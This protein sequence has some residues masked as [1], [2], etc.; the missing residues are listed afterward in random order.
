MLLTDD[1]PKVELTPKSKRALKV[2][3]RHA[4]QWL[5]RS[6]IAEWLGKK[7]LN[8][9]DI[10]NLDYMVAVGVIEVRKGDVS[11]VIVP[12]QWEYRYTED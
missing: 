10:K 3:Q 1:K 8:P 6:Q 12:Y 5:S 9:N 2:L 7:R 11:G 4:G